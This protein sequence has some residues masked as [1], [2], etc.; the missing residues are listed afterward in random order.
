[1]GRDLPRRLEIPRWCLVVEDVNN[2]SSLPMC[3]P[4][5]ATVAES[6]TVI[7]VEDPELTGLTTYFEPYTI[8]PPK[9]E[10]DI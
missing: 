10:G 1:M 4:L 6:E 5:T 7:A 8:A 3:R 9:V 2:L